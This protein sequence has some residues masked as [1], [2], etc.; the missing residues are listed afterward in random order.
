MSP[1]SSGAARHVGVFCCFTASDLLRC[2]HAVPVAGRE[3]FLAGGSQRAQRWGKRSAQSGGYVASI[4][5]SSL[6]PASSVARTSGLCIDQILQRLFV[7]KKNTSTTMSKIP[8]AHN[9][10]VK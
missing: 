4:Y 6:C 7:T 3:T 8:P 2:F 1:C 5:I 9:L 10:T